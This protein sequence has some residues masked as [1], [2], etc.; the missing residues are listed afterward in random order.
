MNEHILLTNL[1]KA[2]RMFLKREITFRLFKEV[3]RFTE[4]NLKG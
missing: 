1:L 3:I 2:C 4:D